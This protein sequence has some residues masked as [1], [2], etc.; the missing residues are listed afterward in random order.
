MAP[1]EHSSYLSI[2]TAR[3][4]GHTFASCSKLSHLLPRSVV[5]IYGCTY[6][7]R[8][9]REAAGDASNEVQPSVK[10]YYFALSAMPGV[11]ARQRNTASFCFYFA[12]RNISSV[13]AHL[14]CLSLTLRENVRTSLG[15]ASPLSR[16]PLDRTFI[17]ALLPR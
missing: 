7:R 10:I 16:E 9:G 1:V 15:L 3:L 12:L 2:S 14:A 13:R 4:S 6:A 5:Y 17:S 11:S 8:E